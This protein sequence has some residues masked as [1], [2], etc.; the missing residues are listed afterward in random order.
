MKAIL[1][2]VVILLVAVIVAGGVYALVE[3]TTLVSST[4]SEHGMPPAMT[5]ADGSTIQMMERPVVGGGEHGASFTRGLSEV[6]ITL[7]KLSGI[8]VVVLLIQSLVAKIQKLKIA[9]LT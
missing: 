9:T 4:E 2:L 7:A 6:L 3:N 8:T 1:H 5:N